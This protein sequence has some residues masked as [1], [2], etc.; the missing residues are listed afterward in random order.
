MEL[1][2][3]RRGLRSCVASP[4]PWARLPP[5]ALTPSLSARARSRA[6]RRQRAT[7]RHPCSCARQPPP[8]ACA[9]I[10]RRLLLSLPARRRLP[11]L[12]ARGRGRVACLRRR[13]C[14]LLFAPHAGLDRVSVCVWADR[15]RQR[16]LMCARWSWAIGL[17]LSREEGYGCALLLRIGSFRCSVLRT[18]TPKPRTVAELPRYKS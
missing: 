18:L 3:D 2:A 5:V 14:S 12:T 16:E 13:P 4:P 17:T 15:L 9:T 10:V 1:Y 7:C 11:A 8:P 6:G